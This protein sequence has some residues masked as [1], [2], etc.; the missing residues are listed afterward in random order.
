[1]DRRRF[2]YLLGASLLAA[3]TKAQ[4]RYPLSDEPLAG[5]ATDLGSLSGAPGEAPAVVRDVTFERILNARSE[6]H[7]WLTYYGAYNGQRYSPLDQINT[8]NVQD[9]RPAWQ[10][11]FGSFGLQASEGTYSFEAAPIVVDGVMYLSG[12]DGWVWTLDAATGQELWRYKHAIPIDTPLCCGNVNRGVA[13]AKGKVFMATQNAHL[14]ALDATNGEVVWRQVFGDVRAGESA[15]LAPLIVK[16][17]V[18]VGNSGAEYGV[19]GHIDAFDIDTGERVWRRYNVPA[20]GD[21]GS[22]TWPEGQASLRGGGSA[23]ITGTYDP[24]LDLLFWGTGN[25]S[26]V[27]D[28]GPRPGDNLYTNSVLAINPDDGDLRWYYQFTPHDVWDYDGNN[29]NI[30]FDLDGRKLLGHF[31][32]N[33]YFFVL[34]RTDGE[35]VRVTPFAERLTWGEINT[36]GTVTPRLLPTEGGVDISPGPGGGKEWV[37]AAYSPRTQLFYVP[38][39]ESR[40]NFRVESVEFKESLPYYGGE[41]STDPDHFGYVKAFDPSTGEE[42]WA[43]RADKPMVASVLATG[44]DLVFAGEPTG[45]FNAFDARTG[46]LLWQHQ[47]GS[48]HHSNPTSYSIDGKQYIAVPVGWGG[49]VKGFAPGTIGVPRGDTLVVFALP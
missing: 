4:P 34:D 7:N 31:D 22:E 3:C 20:P 39:I 14:V 19:R 12:W 18:I 6:P 25:P 38:I 32:K 28:E 5:Q 16:N 17:L 29:E 49:W 43:W 23:W 8:G 47:T 9:L 45:E 41:A 24:E 1:M 15:T 21:P 48:G 35:L 33:G 13:V 11:Q 40:G 26:P 10:F 44:G 42:V 46:E 30:L 37:H 36:V 2:C 27:F